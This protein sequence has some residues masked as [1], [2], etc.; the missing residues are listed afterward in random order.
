MKDD[1]LSKQ[2]SVN[3]AREQICGQNSSVNDPYVRLRL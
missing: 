1:G 3:R 2:I